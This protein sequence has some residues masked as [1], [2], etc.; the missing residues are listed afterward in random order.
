RGARLL[1]PAEEIVFSRL[2]R[3][4]LARKQVTGAKAGPRSRRA[5]M[6]PFCSD[7]LP[8]MTQPPIA[9]QI[10]RE[11]AVLPVPPDNLGQGTGI[12]GGGKGRALGRLAPFEVSD[13]ANAAARRPW[14]RGRA[15]WQ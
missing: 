12:T 8:K 7:N 3:V 14:S 13:C 4:S 5:K 15:S 6:L 10:A 11:T 1:G 9:G 2:G